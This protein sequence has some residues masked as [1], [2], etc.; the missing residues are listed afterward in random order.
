MSEPHL[1]IKHP[2]E[3]EKPDHIGSGEW[4]EPKDMED[5]EES[6]LN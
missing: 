3:N 2:S 4:R 6:T 5:A 1:T